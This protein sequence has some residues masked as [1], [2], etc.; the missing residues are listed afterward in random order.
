LKPKT[1][2]NVK[3][4]GRNPIGKGDSGKIEMYKRYY[5]E[6]PLILRH[7]LKVEQKS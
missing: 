7:F 3:R 4:G 1:T 5:A 6:I 2:I